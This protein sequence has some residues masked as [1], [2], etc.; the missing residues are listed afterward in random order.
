M[1]M[2]TE[3]EPWTDREKGLWRAL[4]TMSVAFIAMC[5]V[6]IVWHAKIQDYQ[7]WV[8]ACHEAGGDEFN[9]EGQRICLDQQ[10]RILGTYGKTEVRR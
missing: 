10:G 6:N 1:T 5:A 9:L 8:A 7:D 2:T 4:L 3:P